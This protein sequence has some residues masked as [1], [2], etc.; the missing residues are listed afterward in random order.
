ME[1][2]IE[3]FSSIGMAFFILING[4]KKTQLGKLYTLGLDKKISSDYFFISEQLGT[5]KP[6]KKY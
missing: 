1:Q 6:D 3:Y 2:L 4:T 5:A